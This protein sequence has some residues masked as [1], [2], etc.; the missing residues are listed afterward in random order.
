MDSDNL[1]TGRR[2]DRMRTDT[3]NRDCL[4][5]TSIKFL[6]FREMLTSYSLLERR[7]SEPLGIS[8]TKPQGSSEKVRIEGKQ[9]HVCRVRETSAHSTASQRE[10]ETVDPRSLPAAVRAKPRPWIVFLA[11]SLP[12][13]ACFH[14]SQVWS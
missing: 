11:F 13:E 9:S 12:R 4:K 6:I 5:C 7:H 3:F 8:G 10:E 1:P 2:G 14:R